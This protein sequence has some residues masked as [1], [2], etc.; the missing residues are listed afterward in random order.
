MIE[1]GEG[2]GCQTTEAGS[3]IE[4]KLG[5]FETV[6][7]A[8]RDQERLRMQVPKGGGRAAVEAAGRRRSGGGAGGGGEAHQSTAVYYMHGV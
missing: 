2:E 4:E 3:A 8:C 1:E 6:E 5:M 7:V